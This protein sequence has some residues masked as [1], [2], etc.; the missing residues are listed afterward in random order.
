[1]SERCDDGSTPRRAGLMAGSAA[2]GPGAPRHGVGRCRLQPQPISPLGSSRCL[3]EV[4]RRGSGVGDTAGDVCLA[5]VFHLEMPSGMLAL[6]DYTKPQE[7]HREGGVGFLGN[8]CF[9]PTHH[10]LAELHP[11][12]RSC[13]VSGCSRLLLLDKKDTLRFMYG[14]NIGPSKGQGGDGMSLG[15]RV[16]LQHG[17]KVPEPCGETR[18]DLCEQS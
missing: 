12:Q 16:W 10:P 15:A 4:G 18:P 8:P 7:I 6:G 9:T 2:L 11:Q 13:T 17:V 1:M 14:C 5:A 3:S